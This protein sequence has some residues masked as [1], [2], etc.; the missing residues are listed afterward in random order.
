MAE[1]CRD[2][3]TTPVRIGL[4]LVAELVVIMTDLAEF[5][6]GAVALNLLF[7]ISLFS[8]GVIIAVLTMVILRTRLRG[9]DSFPAV[10]VALLFVLTLAF[11]YLVARSPFSP[12]GAGA[13]PR[14]HGM[15]IRMGSKSAGPRR[16]S[17]QG[18]Q[19]PAAS[20]RPRPYQ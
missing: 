15:L 12:A 18:Q 8:G 6:G 3:T 17:R 1:V 2:H 5:V 16:R 4:W 9:R 13:E 14:W 7:G 10:V 20:R 11:G 19:R